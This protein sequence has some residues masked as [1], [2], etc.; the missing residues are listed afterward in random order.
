MASNELALI[1]ALLY[2]LTLPARLPGS[3]E[4]KNIDAEIV[5]CFVNTAFKFKQELPAEYKTQYDQVARF[6]KASQ[7]ATTVNGGLSKEILLK[8]FVNFHAAGLGAF[9]ILH[10]GE[11]NAGLL[12]WKR[13]K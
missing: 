10:I 11:Q 3:E 1:D 2:H 5:R 7:A 12:I 6:L 9:L 8:E 4:Y 13:D